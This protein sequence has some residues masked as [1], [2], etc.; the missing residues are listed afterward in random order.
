VAK[1]SKVK[2]FPILFFVGAFAVI[3]VL[4]FAANR[5]SGLMY[6]LQFP[7]NNGVAN[8]FTHDNYLAAA[9]HDEQLYVW[10]W[11]NLASMPKTIRIQSDHAALLD[12]GRVVSV[13]RTNAYDVVV[14]D[15]NDGRVYKKIPVAAEG[16]H[17]QLAGNRSGRT[18]MMMLEEADNA[19]KNAPKVML[20]DCNTGSLRPISELT[21]AQ[22]SKLTGMAVSDDGRLVALAGEKTGQGL[23]V[24]VNVEQKRMA[25][26]EKLPDLQKIKSL[27]FSTDGRVI[28]VRGTDNT[29]QILDVQTGKILKRLLTKREITSTARD[30]NTQTLAVSADGRF[31]AACI[32]SVIFV[33]NCTTEKIMLRIP[34]GHKLVSGLAFSPDSSFLATSDACRQEKNDFKVKNASRKEKN[35]DST[36]IDVIRI[37]LLR[38]EFYDMK[39]EFF[40]KAI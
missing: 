16:K 2:K 12:S 33:W 11:Q 25:W 7:L 31:M 32:G 20:V 15:L 34:T 4:S 28:Y 30:Q 26:A 5:R 21:E 14:T 27:L 37:N 13:K 19:G 6:K 9:C 18:V 17:V 36:K 38:R 8:L 10:D 3:V 24:L 23:V 39:P 40:Q 1:L 35:I 22:E 29:V